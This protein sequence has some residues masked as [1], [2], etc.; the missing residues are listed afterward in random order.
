VKAPR[1]GWAQARDDSWPSQMNATGV[2]NS[3]KTMEQVTVRVAS[4]KSRIDEYPL[5]APGGI[6]YNNLASGPA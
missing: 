5:I 6:T 1:Y 2:A 4:R 3:G